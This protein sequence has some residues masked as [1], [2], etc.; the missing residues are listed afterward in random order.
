MTTKDLKKPHS[1]IQ[2]GGAEIWRE[3]EKCREA[4]SHGSGTER[5]QNM[6]SHIHMW[7]IKIRRHTSGARDLSP[8]PDY[9]AAQGSSARKINPHNF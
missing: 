1:S 5:W 4:Q 8:K 2:V 7:W 6:W 9:P 3:V